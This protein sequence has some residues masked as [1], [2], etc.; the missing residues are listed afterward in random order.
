MIEFSTP[1]YDLS[2]VDRFQ[3]PTIGNLLRATNQIAAILS[4]YPCEHQDAGDY[5]HSFLIYPED[6][7]TTKDGIT[8]DVTITKTSSL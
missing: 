4:D 8:T 6:V 3:K 5:G 1:D 7:W 2:N